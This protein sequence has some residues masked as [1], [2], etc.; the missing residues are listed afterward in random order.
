MHTIKKGKRERERDISLWF[1]G[2]RH[3]KKTD[4]KTEK[5]KIKMRN[6]NVPFNTD[7]NVSIILTRIYLTWT[8]KCIFISTELRIT[9]IECSLTALLVPAMFWISKH[10]NRKRAIH[11]YILCAVQLTHNGS[12]YTEHEHCTLCSDVLMQCDAI[13]PTRA[14]KLKEHPSITIKITNEIIRKYIFDIIKGKC[15]LCCCVGRVMLCDM[16]LCIFFF[17]F[18]SYFIE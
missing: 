11:C 1:N 12:V 6:L 18:V 13:L 8:W 2:Y 16:I 7:E 3:H 5:S 15:M 10:C 4:R 9:Y 17:S 14:F